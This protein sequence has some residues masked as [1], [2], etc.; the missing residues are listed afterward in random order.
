MSVVSDREQLQQSTSIASYDVVVVGAGPY[1]LTAAA[2]LLGRGLKVAIFGKPLELWREHMPKGMF[3]RSHWWA[4]NLSD[5]QK[6]YSFDRFFRQFG[7]KKVYPVPAERFIDYALWFQENAVP[8]VDETYVSSVSREGNQF[9]LTLEDGRKVRSK[10]VIMAIGLYYYANWPEEYKGFPPELLTHSFDHKDFSPFKGKTLL[11]IGGGQSAV[12]YSALLVESGAKVHL[13]SRRPIHWLAPDRAHERSLW[14]K[15]KA[16]DSGIA[17]GWKN[18]ALEYL[19]Y[20]FYLFPKE[21]KERYIRN[22]Y[23][24]AAADWLRDRVLG[25][26]FLH[27]GQRIQEMHVADGGMDVTL[28]NGEQFHVDHVMLATGYEVNLERLYMID[29]ALRAQIKT[30]RGVPEL[31][32]WFESSVPGLYF[33]GLTALHDFGPLYRFV[34]GAKAAGERVAAAVARHVARVRA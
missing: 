6:K 17:P 33:I 13:V 30:D 32:H 12:E 28:K 19:P 8:Q 21:R 23:N 9:L 7:Y 11:V 26:V 14:E 34:V 25:K 29:P 4:T 20:M 5:P 15:I 18:W 24:A 3:L 22:H 31:S 27:E 16:P 2:Q 10:A 1:G